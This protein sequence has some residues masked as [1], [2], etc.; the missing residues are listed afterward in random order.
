M[1][2]KRTPPRHRDAPGVSPQFSS[3][4]KELK[5]LVRDRIDT[6]PSLISTK[7]TPGLVQADS[8]EDE[9]LLRQALQGVRPLNDSGPAR[10]P[11]QPRISHKVVSEDAEVLAELSDLVS[12]RSPFDVTETAEYTEGAR[13]GVDPR[14]VTR[15][16]RGQFSVQA[17]IDLHGMIQAA[18][19][20]AL[21]AF[22]V[23]SVHKGR[24]CVLVVHGRGR[25]SPGGQPIL[26][27]ASVQWLSRGSLSGYILAFTTARLAD[28]GA[29]ALYVLLRRER[30]RAKFD[31][32]DGAKRRN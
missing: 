28:G 32:L 8:Q 20:D 18:A 21:A 15:L 2:R 12:G 25:G 11:V 29:G 13:V 4:F 26:K 23:E 6:G 9:S 17:H 7:P 31:V 19:R 1:A 10:L 14:L 27:R 3:P 16:R 24:R 30:R 22:V 5:K